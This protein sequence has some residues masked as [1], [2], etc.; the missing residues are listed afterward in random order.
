[1]LPEIAELH[2]VR[3]RLADE[4]AGRGRDE[5]L[6]SVG[7]ASDPARTM[8]VKPILDKI[9]KNP[10]NWRFGDVLAHDMNGDGR[11]INMD[12]KVMFVC[13]HHQTGLFS[14][15]DL[16]GMGGPGAPPIVSLRTP[17]RWVRVEAAR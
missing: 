17:E 7:D 8:D 5:D 10:E 1:M 16:C 4:G 13:R 9:N 6:P 11:F 3:K 15:V 14:S 12:V 2:A